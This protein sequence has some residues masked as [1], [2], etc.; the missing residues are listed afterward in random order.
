MTRLRL[1]FLSFFILILGHT[2]FAQDSTTLL[3]TDAGILW[4]HN[5]GQTNFTIEIKGNDIQPLQEFPFISVDKRPMQVHVLAID[6]FYQAKPQSQANSSAILQ[7]HQ[8]WEAEHHSKLLSTKLKVEAEALLVNGREALFWSYQMPAAHQSDFQAQ[9]FLTI[10]I[11]ND[12]LL[13]NTPAKTNEPLN[14][15]RTFLLDTLKTIKVSKTIFNIQTLQEE[16]R[17]SEETIA[18]KEGKLRV[19]FVGNSYTYFNNLPQLLAGLAA[20]AKP[21]QMIETEMVT[22]GGATLKL[23]WSGGKPQT[24]L[25]SG[26]W[27]YVVLQEQSTLGLARVVDG[28]PQIGDPKNFHDSVRLIVPEIKKAGAKPLLYMT[29]ARKDSPDKQPLLTEAYQSIGK[30]LGDTV[31]PVGLAWQA[32]LKA[33]PNLELHVADKSHPTPVGSYLA[34]CVFYA[35]L[36]GKSPEGLATRI[37]GTVIDHMGKAGDSQGEL[38]NLSKEDAAFLQKIAWDTVQQSRK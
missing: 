24:A 32:A 17:Q 6:E 33:R 12:L 5:G 38:V 11:G 21:S 29:W 37:T 34:A 2:G 20:S 14:T 10:V 22:V 30:E 19:L 27:D 31:A 35:T 15:S 25:A 7:A 9:L 28:I 3:K 26:K 13:L 4:V 1:G 23:L 36:F 18:S 16:F 8:N